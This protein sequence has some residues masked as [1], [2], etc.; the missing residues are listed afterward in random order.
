[1]T[2]QI[3]YQVFLADLKRRRD[4]LDAAIATIESLTGASGPVAG[5][6]TESATVE[7][8][9]FF[10]LSIQDAAKKFL[11]IKKRPHSAP[12]I[13][14]ALEQGGY[15]HQSSDFTQ[16]VSTTLLRVW[17]RD[18]TIVKLPDKKWGL[19]EWYGTPKPRAVKEREENKRAE[20]GGQTG[21]E[22]NPAPIEF[23]AASGH[24]QLS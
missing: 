20:S 18:G 8:D 10:S 13:A 5:G 3:N 4:E 14:R 6:A 12:Q 17:E 9:S 24:G 22:S 19:G 11:R 23:P 16:T 15:I 2:D 7:S 1:M 21:S